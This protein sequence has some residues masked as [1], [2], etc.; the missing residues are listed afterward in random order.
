MYCAF[1]PS[2][3]SPV[4]KP[5][6][7]M[8]RKAAAPNASAKSTGSFNVSGRK[9]GCAGAMLCTVKLPSL[10]IFVVSL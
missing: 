5:G 1:V 4:R 7:G 6:P 2:G 3:A 8:L 9:S 10:S